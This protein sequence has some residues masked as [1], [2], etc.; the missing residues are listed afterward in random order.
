MDDAPFV[1][2]V[3]VSD[4]GSVEGG[5]GFLLVGM[6]TAELDLSSPDGSRCESREPWRV[7]KLVWVS[8]CSV[9]ECLGVIERAGRGGGEWEEARI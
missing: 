2:A 7:G 5:A 9:W 3:I 4:D 6:M 1:C 8:L